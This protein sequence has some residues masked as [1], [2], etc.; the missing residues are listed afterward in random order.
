MVKRILIVCGMVLLIAAAGAAGLAWHLHRRALP[1]YSGT[2]TINGPRAS[3]EILRDR[4]GT[5]HIFAESLEDAAYGAGWAVA[6]DRLFHIE[7]LRRLSQGRLAE[8]VGAA[9]LDVDKLHRALDLHGEGKRMFQRAS[10][11]VRAMAESYAAGVNAYAAT[12]GGNLPVE[13][14]LLRIG[15]RPL[16]ADDLAGVLPYMAFSLMDTWRMEPVYESL[17]EKLGPERFARLLPDAAGGP[18][19]AYP[20]SASLAPDLVKA[21][22]AAAERLGLAAGGG[23]SNNWAVAAGK[24][25]SGHAMLAN[26]PHLELALPAVWYTLHL[27]T[28]E[29]EVA[30]VTIPGF[31]IVT[32][33]HNRDIAWGLTNLMADSGDFFVERINP[34]NPRQVMY[35]GQWV[36][37]MEREETIAVKGQAPVKFTV[38][39]TPHGPLVHE[40]MKGQTESLS[41]RWTVNAASDAAELDGFLAINMAR[42]WQEFRAGVARMGGVAQ[43]FAYADRHGNIGVQAGGRI[44][45]RQGVATGHRYRKGWDG[46]EEWSGFVP[47]DRM[48]RSYNPPQ[49]WLA[50]ANTAPFGRPAP[51]YLATYY[52]P[53]DRWLRIAEVLQGKDKLTVT[54]L[55]ALQNDHVWFRARELAGKIRDAFRG[56]PPADPTERKVLKLF[57]RWN[58]EMETDSVA[59]AVFASFFPA[60]FQEIFADE[61]GVELVKEVQAVRNLQATLLQTVLEGGLTWLDRVDTPQREDWADVIRPAF[62]RAVAELKAQLGSDPAS[63]TWGRLHTFEATHPLGRV[64]WL[65]P[66]FNRGP[67]PVPG[68][69]MTVGKMQYPHGTFKMNHGA[70]MRQI[71]DFADLNAALVVLPG[72]QSGIPASHHYADGLALWLAGRYHPLPM[73]RT[74]IEQHLQ[75]RLLLQPVATATGR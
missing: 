68:S 31:P 44:P 4:W 69:P 65:A 2:V 34:D 14:A 54:D 7:L 22:I 37:L 48:P 74:V 61:M 15:F 6:Q 3:V 59:A 73:D 72:G 17:A 58:G 66:Y 64:R 20:T 51:F 28:P 26:D 47:F 21:G 23:G 18:M 53:R 19:P 16:A 49:G 57:D 10:P 30:G 45:V 63:W 38:R 12:L 46:S 9:A 42:N 33:G 71:T 32:I 24:S 52:E 13:F 29:L 5:P 70:S 8:A 11:R 40:L 62:S 39:I 75:G 1:H 43:N 25:A 50:T 41:L 36:E 56:H 60:L 27:V 67:T 55:Q 35:R